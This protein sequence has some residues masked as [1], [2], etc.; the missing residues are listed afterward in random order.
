MASIVVTGAG[1]GIGKAIAVRLRA[2]GHDL[3][4]VDVDTE[5]AKRSAAELDGVAVTA[6]IADPA[7][8]AGIAAAAPGATALVNNAAIWTFTPLLD[9]PVDDARRVLDVNVVGTLLAMQA[10]APVIER[11]GGGSI[12]NL[13]SISGRV[14]PPGTGVYSASK[15]AIDALTRAAAVEFGP[16]GIRVNAVAPGI[17]PTEQTAAHYGDE[18]AKQAR[19]EALPLRRL[20]EVDDIADA[21]AFFVSDA[22]RY[23]TGQSVAVDGGY[24]VAGGEFFRRARR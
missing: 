6:D 8:V 18:A 24:S 9:T 4:V 3:V 20:A 12:V 22:S 21:I 7:A 17:V 10:L 23:I 19:A 2:D 5:A 1:R 11:N 14:H 15:A 16:M 13:S